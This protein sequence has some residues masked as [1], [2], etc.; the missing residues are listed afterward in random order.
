MLILNHHDAHSLVGLYDILSANMSD[1]VLATSP[2]FR[3]MTNYQIRKAILISEVQTFD[4]VGYWLNK[5]RRD[6]A[7]IWCCL[8]R[9]M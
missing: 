7:C 9:S 1:K 5:I 4:L 3:D 8:A 2:L 6:A